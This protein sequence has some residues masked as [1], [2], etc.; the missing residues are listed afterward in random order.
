VFFSALLVVALSGCAGKVIKTSVSDGFTK[1]VFEWGFWS[2]RCQ[3]TD[4]T[5]KITQKPEFGVAEIV[6]GTMIIARE[7][8][9]GVR[10]GCE[11]KSVATKVVNYTSN[12]GFRGVD[13]MRL[14]VF[15][16]SSAPRL[17]TV[18]VKVY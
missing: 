8:A 11:G 16:R 14:T 10:T 13:K 3:A 7:T 5:I 2:G 18:E 9:S 17:F 15:R 12:K 1:P 6:S 4:F